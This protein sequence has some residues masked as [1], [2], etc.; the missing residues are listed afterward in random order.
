M[1]VFT[2]AELAYLAANG[3]SAAWP[4]SARTARPISPP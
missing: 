3:A 4:P 2:E 1:D